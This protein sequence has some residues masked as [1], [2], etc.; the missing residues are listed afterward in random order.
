MPPFYADLHIHSKFSRAC[1]RDCDL[2]HLALVGRRKGIGVIGTGDFTH[3][4]W[5]EELSS[6]LVP[7]EPGLFRLREDLERAVEARLPASCRGPVRFL[8]SVEISTI[9]KRAERT[10]KVHHLL[11]M[12]DLASAARCTAALR[13]IGNLASDGRP[14]LGLD[15]RDLL[16]ITLESGEGA[17]LVPAHAW[18]PW[19]SPLGSKSGFDRVEDCYADL[20][21][22]I[23]AL[24]TGL[25]A[26][27]EMCWRV[28]GLDRYRLVSNSDAHSPPALGREAT[29][30]DTDLDYWAIRRAL[31]TGQGF[32]GTVE[33][34]PEEGKYHL[35]G[36]RKCGVRMEPAETRRHGGLC[37]VC[38]K[39]P[40]VGVLHRVEE[41][42]D[43]PPGARPPGAAGFRNLIQLPELAGEVLG[44]GPRSKAV[45][46]VVA[47]LVDRLGPELDILERIPVD[48]IA[49]AGPPLL[50][51]AIDR[52]RRGAVIREAGYDGEYGIIRVFTPDELRSSPST[53]TLFEPD[54]TLPV[55]TPPLGAPNPPLGARTPTPPGAPAP[56][57]PV[58]GAPDPV[59]GVLGG[60]DPEQR[61]A[62]GAGEGPLLVVAG[63]GTGK[64]RTLTHRLAYLVA[65]RGLAAE[66]CLAITFTRRACA[67]LQERLD[68]LVP[69]DARRMVVTTFHG[70]GLRILREQHEAVGLGP[71]FRVADD[72]ERLELLTELLGC[73]EREARR[74]LPEL[75]RRKRARAARWPDLDAEPSEVAGPLARYEAAM[76]K[77]DLVDLDDLLA[78]PV[79]L[80]AGDPA[81]AA[82]YR[83]RFGFV[84]VDEYQ[85]VDE[86]QYRLLRLLTTPDANLCVIG[87]PDQAIY[88]FRGADVGFFLRFAEDFPSAR[89]VRLTRNY[90]SS[91]AIVAGALQAIAPS[92][93]VA[94][95]ELAAVA[96]PQAPARIT[97][98]QA[99][100]DLA[101]AEFVVQTI[102]RLLGGASFLSL[103]SGRADGGAE[104]GLSFADVAVLY[105]TDAQAGPLAEALGRAGMPFQKRSHDRLLDRP[106]VRALVR[107]L[108]APAGPAGDPSLRAR[109]A[110]AAVG[111]GP[112]EGAAEALELLAPL[113]ERCDGDLD[114]FLAELALGDEVDTWDPRADRVSLLTLHAAKGLEF[115]VVF[116]VG[117]EDGLLPLRFGARSSPTETA[118]ERRLFF[119]GMTRA[120]SHLFLSH[121]RRRAWRGSVREAE[122]SPFLADLEAALL[123]QAHSPA[124]RRAQPQAPAGDQLS[125]L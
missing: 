30:L 113:A 37:P 120:R 92:T 88:G 25:S 59:A 104:H 69:G 52:V 1:S 42:A 94:G 44:V 105:R 116:L 125:L 47:G 98:H 2:E 89:T 16:E 5:F 81:L 83:A 75:V 70:L 3:P 107:A 22:H 90:R 63:P 29:V 34:F 115:P 7:A 87:D 99:A 9:Y 103:D 31:E 85:D 15:S 48:D 20:A 101:E 91:P 17:Y 121:A 57:P 109:L 100:S 6:T 68:A 66:R 38:G 11:Y 58:S 10:R 35:D 23:F 40:T 50:A 96:G 78:L 51:E 67:E 106:A 114:R 45:T 76:R 124:R 117:C 36:H 110:A 19:F 123:E 46:A 111:P 56:R 18:T 108:R 93:L 77:L 39:P 13:R 4:R 24:E 79:T 122:P 86:L 74:L 41:L 8:L 118:E 112:G 102:D 80:L 32:A 28:S 95:R 73:P 65:E 82:R 27:P 14:I 61:V 62:A 54:P 49:K 72:T 64:T 97:M 119:V 55:P 43:R 71:G 84:A 21:E 12:P 33:F 26:D 53:A 60:L